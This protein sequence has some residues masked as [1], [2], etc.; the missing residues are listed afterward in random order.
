MLETNSRLIY[1]DEL[2]PPEGYEFDRAIAT[3]FTLDLL[4]MLMAP[5][6]V[7]LFQVE[8][9]DDLMK[10]PLLILEALRKTSGKISIFCQ[11]GYISVP[12]KDSLLYSL[13]ESA[14][15]PVKPKI[16]DGVFHPKIWLMRFVSKEEPVLYRFL[17]MSRNLTFDR[18]WDTVLKL[19]GVVKEREKGYSRNRPLSDFINALSD[20][21]VNDISK[22]S[23]SNIQVIRDEIRN[24]D[25]EMPSGFENELAFYPS[26]IDGYVKQPRLQ[27]FNRC[28]IVSPFLTN[29]IVSNLAESG[30]S[31]ILVS[32]NESLDD[33]ADD[34]Y[35]ALKENT[36]IYVMEDA[37]EEPEES[38]DDDNENSV[39]DLK[40]K[41]EIKELN[42]RTQ[43]TRG[44]HA[45]L[46]IKENGW[47]ADIVTG[48]ANATKPGFTGGNIEFMTGLKGR[49]SKVG[50]DSF[51]GNDKD[52]NSFMSLIRPYKRMKVKPEK[53]E[54]LERLN[55]LV[56]NVRN[57][58]I[59][60]GLRM[61][62][63]SNDD[64]TYSV[65]IK[66]NKKFKKIPEHV[67]ISC[68]PITL[69]E[70]SAISVNGQ[71]S[72][73]CELKFKSVSLESLTS[74]VAFMIKATS[75]KREVSA[76]FVLNLQAEG[77]PEDRDKNI[78]T[79]IIKDKNR[80]IRYLLLILADNPNELLLDELLSSSSVK[81]NNGEDIDE[82]IIFD[83]NIPLLEE[84][85]R[86][87]SRDP[88][89]I[90]RI[91]RLIDDIKSA[92]KSEAV[93]PEHFEETWSAFVQAINDPN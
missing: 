52:S 34:I 61:Y 91:Q 92:E 17:C 36:E 33:I 57:A 40:H 76:S 93:I 56:D 18:S 44:L 48:S 80:F 58:I 23:K 47:Y 82:V 22:E 77:M 21:S 42:I 27:D 32:K 10:D 68:Y 81:K 87:F 69:R 83:K 71:S 43:E 74:F 2:K 12:Q 9:R 53:D 72:S 29:D 5:L 20:I 13:L 54:E 25:F 28:L 73:D 67:T 8:S 1:L 78:L 49:K 6:T 11:D 84:L 86:A 14:V 38:S 31:N 75:G 16:G 50:I 66:G 55:H 59:S 3:T 7:S 89:K 46:I 4:A 30:N 79:S 90:D 15:I 65:L 35:K 85:V 51:I 26:G 41:K 39:A 70:E 64:L 24:V 37:A 60:L 62:I 63:S 19:E 88:K 45:K